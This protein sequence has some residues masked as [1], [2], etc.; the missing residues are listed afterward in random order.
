MDLHESN[1]T[2]A[3]GKKRGYSGWIKPTY[4]SRHR[5]LLG[6]VCEKTTG[7]T[8]TDFANNAE[9]A[10]VTGDYKT[11]YKHFYYADVDGDLKEKVVTDKDTE[12]TSDD[13]DSPNATREDKN[14]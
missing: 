11:I 9:D 13:G 7:Y 12:S 3:S 10:F 2:P 4:Y 5:K 1:T 6:K 8:L 14:D